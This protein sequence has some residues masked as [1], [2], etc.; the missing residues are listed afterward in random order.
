VTGGYSA[1]LFCGMRRFGEMSLGAILGALECDL[2]VVPRKSSASVEA[3]HLSADDAGKFER[4]AL[5]VTGE[6]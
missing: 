2:V 5:P 3:R 4:R 6:F 1:K